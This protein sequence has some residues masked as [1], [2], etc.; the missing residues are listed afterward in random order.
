MFGM[1]DRPTG[2]CWAATS[3]F[4]PL[5]HRDAIPV[6]LFV[7]GVWVGKLGRLLSWSGAVP[8]VDKQFDTWKRKMGSFTVTARKNART[9]R[10]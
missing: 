3:A 6:S 10:R 1:G 5:E 2:R 4:D 8:A 7:L 9:D